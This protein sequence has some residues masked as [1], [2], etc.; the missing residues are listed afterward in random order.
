MHRVSS[1]L[2]PETRE[3]TLARGRS[4]SGA[5]RVLSRISPL[6]GKP[7]TPAMLVDV[8]KLLTAYFAHVPD[9]SVSEQ[10]VAFGTSGHRGRA[11]EC[12]FNESHVLSISQAICDYRKQQ[13]IG[14]PLY[15][16][17]D[18]H[19]LSVPAAAGALEVLAANDVD[20]MLAAHDEYTP[21]PVIS[22]AILAY[23]RGRDAGLADGIVI[24]PSHSP[25]DNG[26]FKYNAPSGGPAAR[27]VTEWIE[28]RANA[29]LLEG[30]QGV[31][32]MPLA[33]AQRAATTHR[34]DFLTA[35]VTDLGSVLDMD[36]I[37]GSN[38]KLGVDP[39]GGAGVHYWSAIA[40]RYGLNLK[41]VSEVVDP[42]F[43]FM[44]LDWDGVIRM[45]PS[46]CYAMQRLIGLKDRFDIAFACDTDHDQHGI[47]TRDAGLMPPNQYLA[48]ALFYLLQHRCGWSNTA[49]FGTMVVSGQRNDR[50]TAQLGR[51][52]C[53]IPAGFESAAA[54]LVRRDGGV[55]T[56]D[57]DGIVPA[58]LSA[59][60][61]AS[62]GR[63]PAQIYRELVR[64]FGDPMYDAAQADAISG[65]KEIL[66]QFTPQQ[67]GDILKIYGQR[68]SGPGHLRRIVSR[69]QV[70]IDA[71]L[72]APRNQ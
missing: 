47:V 21:T 52:L 54:S 22:H 5:D 32:R 56:T 41:V 30:L 61:T 28:A 6:A 35:Y 18:T 59:E 40:D 23:N 29:L 55:W 44:T 66:A 15:L 7:A 19:A 1:R 33:R 50:V 24:T 14:G 3:M 20:V 42:T 58:L 16:G 11:L 38:L 43:R 46:S 60:I 70:I 12:S 31:K 68:F 39:L 45:D 17:I 13:G 27:E 57:K 49:A 69:A 65:Q 48:V 62:L 10:R 2:S 72:A 53:E 71:A 37:R 34:H 51:K 63:D 26:G 25:P 8:P 9:A 36:A 64:E 4:T 67:V